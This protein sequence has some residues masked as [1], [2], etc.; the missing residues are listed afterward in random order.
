MPETLEQTEPYYELH[1][2]FAYRYRCRSARRL[3]VPPKTLVA[4]YAVAHDLASN[5]GT[6]GEFT[7][8]VRAFEEAL[9]EPERFGTTSDDVARDAELAT[10]WRKLE[11]AGVVEIV[12]GSPEPPHGGAG[13][14]SEFRV[15]VRG[16]AARPRRAPKS[17]AERTARWRAR[18]GADDVT[19]RDECDVAA[20]QPVTRDVATS[21]DAEPS[22]HPA[23][24]PSSQ[25]AKPRAEA[26]AHP[27]NLQATVNTTRRDLG[28]ELCQLVSR[29]IDNARDKHARTIAMHTEHADFL[30]PVARLVAQHGH[31]SV[32]VAAEKAVARGAWS[33]R[34]IEQI[35]SD[36]PTPA[37]RTAVAA[38]SRRQIDPELRAMFDAADPDSPNRAGAA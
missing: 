31:A 21:R 18:K 36:E 26:A 19:K 1:R 37:T 12:T 10:L 24:H 27:S 5:A 17:G 2:N 32:I 14:P 28:P 4:Y 7:T 3:G 16:M 35:L 25:P 8:D 38:A 23:I 13:L 11:E 29:I 20:S 30:R 15:R 6:F 9:G 33:V 34:L 22:I